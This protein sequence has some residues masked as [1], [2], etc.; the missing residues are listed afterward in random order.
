MAGRGYA[1][2]HAPSLALEPLPMAALRGPKL[3]AVQRVSSP[4]HEI[5]R[6]GVPSG[7]T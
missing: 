7:S 3:Y 2:G 4:H 6:E 5:P 1:A